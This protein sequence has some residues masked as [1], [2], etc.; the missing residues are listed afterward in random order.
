VTYW[1]SFAYANNTGAPAPTTADVEVFGGGGG[2][3]L[4]QSLTHYGST[5]QNMG[6]S[7]FLEPFVADDLTSRLAFTSTDTFLSFGIVLDGVGV[8]TT[9]TLPEPG[10]P[11]PVPE[12]STVALFGLGLLGLAVALL[13]RIQ[14]GPRVRTSCSRSRTCI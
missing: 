4:S 6:Y 7:M 13:R 2:S 8:Y 5:L 9:P 12:A 10:P 14:S 3:L 11:N 1:L